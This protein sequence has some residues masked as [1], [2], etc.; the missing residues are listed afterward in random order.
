MYQ[1]KHEKAVRGVLHSVRPDNRYV[2]PI[3]EY[4]LPAQG[5]ASACTKPRF[6]KSNFKRLQKRSSHEEVAA[7]DGA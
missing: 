4:E 6:G 5:R 2:P 7:G 1:V 3:T